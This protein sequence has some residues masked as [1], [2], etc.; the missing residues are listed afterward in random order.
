[1]AAGTN[2]SG[3]TSPG[4]PAGPGGPWGSGSRSASWR[5]PGS[6]AHVCGGL[7]PASSRRCNHSSWYPLLISLEKLVGEP[8][9]W[10][11]L[12]RRQGDARGRGGQ[13]RALGDGPGA[14]CPFRRHGDPSLSPPH[15]PALSAPAQS[16]LTS[17]P[18]LPSAPPRGQDQGHLPP[19]ESPPL[20]RGVTEAIELSPHLRRRSRM[21]ARGGRKRLEL[22]SGAGTREPV[23]CGARATR[24]HIR[25]RGPPAAPPHARLPPP[26]LNVP[27]VTRDGSGCLL[28]SPLDEKLT[29]PSTNGDSG[30]IERKGGPGPGGDNVPAPD[31]FSN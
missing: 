10:P 16:T 26:C 5:A 12:R 19:P 17:A 13:A 30:T 25:G 3:R 1:M 22:G 29:R 15:V 4:A 24:S 20:P 2:T 8:P 23:T 18:V 31:S 6:A 28:L 7:L 14:R 27:F 11:G 9:L 21:G